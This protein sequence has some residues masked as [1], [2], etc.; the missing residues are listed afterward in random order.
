MLFPCSPQ[1]QHGGSLLA[2]S[3]FTQVPSQ[4]TISW[5]ELPPLQESVTGHRPSASTSPRPARAR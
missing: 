5:G 3:P 1:T 2:S 4:V